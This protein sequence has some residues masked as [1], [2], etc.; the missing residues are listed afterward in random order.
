MSAWARRVLSIPVVW[1]AA[2]V[3]IAYR[4]PGF[5]YPIRGG[6]PDELLDFVGIGIVGIGALLLANA[7]ISDISQSAR[8][9]RNPQ[10]WAITAGIALIFGNLRVALLLLVPL[11]LSL[12]SRLATLG[13][14]TPRHI[15]SHSVVR[16]QAIGSKIVSRETLRAYS[17]FALALLVEVWEDAVKPG[18][19]RLRLVELSTYGMVFALLGILWAAREDGRN[20]L[21]PAVADLPPF[22]SALNRTLGLFAAFAWV[23]LA[24]RLSSVQALDESLLRRLHLAGGRAVTVLMKGVS[25][26]AGGWLPYCVLMV[27]VGLC[28]LGRARSLRF[29]I[30]V[31][32]GAMS[33]S[34]ALKPLIGRARPAFA[35]AL[36]QPL[37]NSYP[38]G[39][40]LG[41]TCL[42]GALLVMCLSPDPLKR[43]LLGGAACGWVL[44]VSVSRVYLGQHYPTDVLGAWL[45]GTACVSLCYTIL[46]SLAASPRTCA[47]PAAR[48]ERAQPAEQGLYRP[49]DEP[50][51]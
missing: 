2:G 30:S 12:T 39:H 16:R 9:L 34:G 20:A 23:T 10:G 13:S 43:A 5:A 32:F 3:L 8:G 44:L 22:S 48:P 25:N 18:G 1:L 4:R 17:V 27:A 36:H 33:L 31:M 37:S 7:S 51:S 45:L 11:G 28:V 47:Q 26:S 24:A 41:A 40:V 49:P 38:S 19:P 14:W 50:P 35:S 46:L 21:H 29:L 15:T 6:W 42:A